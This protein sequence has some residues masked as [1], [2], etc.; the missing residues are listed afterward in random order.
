MDNGFLDC[1]FMSAGC[2]MRKKGWMVKK[3]LILQQRRERNI[4]REL[5]GKASV[6]LGL[7]NLLKRYEHKFQAVYLSL[8]LTCTVIVVCSNRI[9]SKDGLFML[10]FLI[11]STK[12]FPP[13]ISSSVSKLDS[14][15]FPVLLDLLRL[16]AS[17][18]R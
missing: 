6:Y 12:L 5:E 2:R 4:Q 3:H 16:N 11:H 17:Q 10:S 15:L 9:A 1:R 14:K 8:Y 13:F 18:S 7:L